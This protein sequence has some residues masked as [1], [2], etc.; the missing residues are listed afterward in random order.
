M[1][2]ISTAFGPFIYSKESDFLSA[3][4]YRQSTFDPAQVWHQAR[5]PPLRSCVVGSFA[6]GFFF[7]FLGVP[8][9]NRDL[10]LHVRP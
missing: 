3:S 6:F 1:R 10:T 8:H 5:R 2:S 4:D 7:L 9:G